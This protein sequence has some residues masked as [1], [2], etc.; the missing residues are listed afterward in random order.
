MRMN[1]FDSLNKKFEPAKSNEE[2][3]QRIVEVLKEW[4]LEEKNLLLEMASKPN[5]KSK[6]KYAKNFL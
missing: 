1:F 5:V 4:N 3:V 6:L 2:A